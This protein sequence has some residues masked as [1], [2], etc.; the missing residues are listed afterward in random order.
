MKSIELSL[1]KVNVS[2]EDFSLSHIESQAIFLRQEIFEKIIKEIFASIEKLA[3][4]TKRCTCGSIPVKNGKE[5]RV[6][7]TIG[8]KVTYIRSRMTCRACGA[9]YYPLDEA[10]EIPNGTKHSIRATE[11]ILDLATDLPY[12]K[13]SRYAEKLSFIEA[14]PQTILDMARLEGQRLLEA[15]EK[16]RKQAFDESATFPA[17]AVHKSLAI[18]QVDSTGINDRA[19]RSWMDTKVGIIYSRSAK[20]SKKRNLILDKNIYAS[21]DSLEKFKQNFYLSCHK[22]GVFS[23]DSVIFVADGMPWI[24]KLQKEMFPKA[25]YLLDPWHLKKNISLAYG[26][27]NAQIAETLAELAYYGEAITLLENI[28]LDIARCRDPDRQVKL[29]D[30]Y[31]YIRSNKEGIENYKKV[32]IMGSGVVEKTVDILVARRFKLRSM[33]WY[34]KN[35][36]KLLRLRLLK[37]NGEWES[38]WEKRFNEKP[39]TEF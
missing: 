10:I 18:V 35:A 27:Q 15:D 25:I 19:T 24:K 32:G 36:A 13:T 34:N 3:I 31:I 38:Y 1:G 6:I 8:G 39:I 9:N 12:A 4:K 21:L 5:K 26:K 16:Q 29:K 33:S 7:C 14:S 37:L 30:L 22:M 28:K 2:I 20:V 11:A 17:E 23:A